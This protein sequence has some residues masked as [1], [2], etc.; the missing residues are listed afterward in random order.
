MRTAIAGNAGPAC[1]VV[2]AYVP[3]PIT[4]VYIR[5]LWCDAHVA[6]RSWLSCVGLARPRVPN[7][8]ASMFPHPPARVNHNYVFRTKQLSA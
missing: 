4:A 8:Y 3:R 2:V 5:F 7:D 6:A 1:R